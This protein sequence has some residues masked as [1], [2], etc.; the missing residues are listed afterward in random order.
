[1]IFQEKD[2]WNDC[3]KCSKT[4]RSKDPMEA[5]APV[6]LSAIYDMLSIAPLSLGEF[7][8]FENPFSTPTEE[9][10]V[11]SAISGLAQVNPQLLTPPVTSVNTQIPILSN[12]SC[13]KSRV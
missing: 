3:R 7:P 1:M 11:T 12:E 4:R 10:P 2:I 8:E 6:I 5:A 9:Q 13:T